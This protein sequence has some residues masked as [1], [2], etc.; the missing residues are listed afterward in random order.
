MVQ[1]NKTMK[2]SVWLF[3]FGLRG[4]A[5]TITYSSQT[6]PH[7]FFNFV[8][9][10]KPWSLLPNAGE[11]QSKL[12]VQG[13]HWGKWLQHLRLHQVEARRQ[14]DVCFTERAWEAPTRSQGSTK[15]PVHTLPAYAPVLASLQYELR[16]AAEQFTYNSVDVTV[17]STLLS[18]KCTFV[19]VRNISRVSII[20]TFKLFSSVC[21]NV[22]QYIQ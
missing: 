22:L 2:C 8:S 18:H 11:V 12:Q 9:K 6:H 1:K 4:I 13:T 3:T 21:V 14:A 5:G 10:S 15:T 19:T 17:I 20:C 16:L 7:W